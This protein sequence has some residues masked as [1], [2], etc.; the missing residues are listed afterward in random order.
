MKRLRASLAVMT[1]VLAFAP[2]LAEA[3][4]VI[5]KFAHF[6]PSN[7]NF[8]NNVAEP[9]C[10]AINKDSGGRMKCQ[11]YPA[12]QLGGTPA[13]LADQIKN[14]VADVGWTSP[15]YTTGRFP[16]TEAL[17]LPFILP[18]DGLGGSRAMWEYTQK[19]GQEDFKDFKLLAIHSTTNVVISTASKPVLT[20]Q[21]MK[22]LKL[23]SPSR[24]TSLVLSAM[25]GTPVNVPLAQ[26]TESIA[27]G[28]IDGTMAPW[29]I[30][31]ATK[32]DEVTKYHME[33]MPGQPA[34]AQTPAVV[35]MN[36]VKYDSLVPDLK[37]VI[38]KRSGP[39][40]VELIGS[41]FDRGNEA[42]R[43]KMA[44]QGNKILVIKSEEYA[45]MKTAAAP[46]E[47]DW[48]KQAN[49]RGLDGTKLAGDAHAIGMKYLV[50]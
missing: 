16:R 13:Q 8:H 1:T 2:A 4:T 43:K 45:A 48:I 28:V 49:A 3:Q 30:L 50:R 17:E 21:D 22:G 41:A 37:A 47:A 34:L 25:G 40:L 33:G 42:A 38:D 23:R 20:L 44:A 9:W 6:L 11:I 19:N 46:I 36:K 29:E 5:I 27:K 14:G 12:L 15:S 39:W 10:E 24:I 35:L 18:S 7:S 31:P 26:T 32:V